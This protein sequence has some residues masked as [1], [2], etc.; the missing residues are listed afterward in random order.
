MTTEALQQGRI[1]LKTWLHIAQSGKSYGLSVFLV[2]VVLFVPVSMFT[3]NMMLGAWSRAATESS[4]ANAMGATKEL[5]L[6][7]LAGLIFALSCTAR[8]CAAAFYFVRISR[9]L[10][11]RMLSSVLRQP[12]LWFDTTPIGRVL[13]RFSQDVSLMDL[14]LPRLFEFTS[15][16]CSVVFTAAL[17]A[18]ALAWPAV[19]I[20]L[21][22]ACLVYRLQKKVQAVALNLQ[23]I[24]LAATSPVMSQTSGFL[25]ALDTIRAFGQEGSFASDFRA[26]AADFVRSYYWIHALDRLAMS[27]FTVLC[28][29]L[30]TLLL[31]MAVLLMARWNTISPEFAGLALALSSGLAQRIPLGL[32]CAG[33]LEKFLGG[34][35]RI[36][37]Y[38]D[39]PWECISSDPKAWK[40]WSSD[41]QE[42]IPI[43]TEQGDTE[44]KLSSQSPALQL[45][46]VNLRY[47][48]GLPLILQGFSLTVWQGEKL[49][50]CGRTGSGKSTLFQACFRMV[51]V[52]AGK[53]LVHGVESMSMSLPTLRS[54]LAIVPQD[55]LMFSGT[56]RS[57]LDFHQRHTEN[58]LWKALKLVNLEAQVR[59]LPQQL[60]DAVCEKGSN[61]SGGT[62]QLLCIARIL[63][64]KQR[65]VFLDECTASVDYET[66]N[67]VQSAVRDAFE[68]CA[69]ISIAHRLLT[70]VECDRIAC[71]DKGQ[72][73][74]CASA[75]ELLRK[76]DGIFAGLVKSLGGDNA[77]EIRNRAAAAGAAASKSPAVLL[78]SPLQPLNKISL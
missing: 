52:E 60:D 43:V 61:F 39:L 53:I 28:I 42:A 40:A 24:M 29:P 32:W 38:A 57:N 46:N 41:P 78:A 19:L 25:T 77:E 16:H 9:Q 30:L 22:L 5:V 3:A 68:D 15:Q 4:E 34:A 18:S 35:Q 20:L 36:A 10:H 14:Q 11:Q 65:V 64:A 8:V 76:P 13:N 72:V 75:H 1:G 51:E 69:V 74:E 50:V 49:G 66:D 2:S 54:Q 63:L 37:E 55:A 59:S 70:I 31:G 17:A 48:P 6:Y 73:A 26:A 7:V 33:T 67:A 47:Q 62:V 58:E 12:V 21:P 56:L 27:L 45:E 71:L 23:R 44:V